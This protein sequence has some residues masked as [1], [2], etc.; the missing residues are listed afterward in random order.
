MTDLSLPPTLPAATTPCAGPAY[1]SGPAARRAWGACPAVFRPAAFCLIAFFLLTCCLVPSA[2]HAAPLLRCRIDQGGERR[3]LDAAPVA[4]PYAVAA[5]DINGR[6]RFKAVVIGD[7]VR[8]DYVKLY[9]YFVGQRQP[10][11]IHQATYLAPVASAATVGARTGDAG[12]DTGWAALTGINRAYSPLLERELE[13]GC[14][15]LETAP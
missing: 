10:V 9:V 7:A 4:D 5:V 15:L 14:A 13:Y 11:L 8:V 12:A 2:L 6:F 1:R 3:V